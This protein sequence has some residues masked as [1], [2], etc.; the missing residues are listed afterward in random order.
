MVEKKDITEEEVGQRILTALRQV[1]LFLVKYI[2][3]SFSFSH[4]LGST[5]WSAMVLRHCLLSF[6]I[7]LSTVFMSVDSLYLFMR[8]TGLYTCPIFVLDMVVNTCSYFKRKQPIYIQLY[9]T[10]TFALMHASTHAHPHIY[11]IFKFK[12]VYINKLCRWE[13]IDCWT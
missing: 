10:D 13:K 2:F 1:G 6:A 12:K 8:S 11:T 7:F 9:I 3:F 5:Q 4:Y